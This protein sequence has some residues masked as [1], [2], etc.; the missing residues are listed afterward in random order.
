MITRFLSI[1]NFGSFTDFDWNQVVRDKGNNIVDF[2]K[3]NI[4]YGRNYSGKTTISRIVDSL[5]KKCLPEDYAQGEFRISHSE[6]GE[7]CECDLSSNEIRTKVYNTDF[8][9]KNLGLQDDEGEILPFAIVGEKNVETEKKIEI[10]T[11]EIGNED[12]GLTKSLIEAQKDYHNKKTRHEKAVTSLES[13]LRNNAREIKNNSKL[14]DNPNYNIASIKTDIKTIKSKKTSLS[15][16]DRSRL[17][18]IAHETSKPHIDPIKVRTP[19]YSNLLESTCKLLSQEVK[20]SKSIQELLEDTELQ[21]WVRRG[22]RL[23]R[24]ERST[25]AFCGSKLPKDLWDRIDAHFS[26]E[27]EDHRAR[28]EHMGAQVDSEIALFKTKVSIP[29]ISIYA[30]LNE[31]FDNQISECNQLLERY[32]VA[33]KHLKSAINSRLNDIFRPSK[34]ESQFEDSQKLIQHQNIINQSIKENNEITTKLGSE[35]QKARVELRLESVHSFI[36]AIEYDEK[37]KEVGE[38]E[39]ESKKAFA[40][41]GEINKQIHNKKVEVD[42]LKNELSDERKGAAKVNS[43]LNHYFGHKALELSPEK[44]S[45]GSRFVLKREGELA[46]N[47]SEGECSLVAFCYFMAKLHEVGSEADDAVIWIDDPI[48]SLITIIFSSFLV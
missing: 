13:S 29:A 19:Q 15:E 6:C 14:F 43:Y 22:T 33:L 3:L 34:Y 12:S 37:I 46:T 32:V 24:D 25:C 16:E 42:T 38:L 10:I 2:S 7:L 26:K 35:Q 39:K 8:V 44:G 17:T 18:K 1:C 27:S 21:E 40:T 47:L 5:D 30:Q 45:M 28:L 36:K 11:Q 31:Q 4:L 41:V 23:H 9:K 48:S 20:P